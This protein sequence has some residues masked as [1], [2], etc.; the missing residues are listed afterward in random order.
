[1]SSQHKVTAGGAS[2][3][4]LLDDKQRETRTFIACQHHGTDLAALLHR[5]EHVVRARKRLRDLIR[6]LLAEG[7]AT[8]TLRD[9][10]APGELARYCLHAL[11]A[12]SSL[13]SQGGG[14]PPCHSDVGRTGAAG[15]R[16]DITQ[17]TPNPTEGLKRAVPQA[18]RVSR[19]GI[20]RY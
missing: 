7:A 1:M 13:Q 18:D 16:D 12:A 17:G 19:L 3:E 9:D 8:G 6:D 5:G 11:E 4:H 15:R 10:V 2:D 14:S 20:G